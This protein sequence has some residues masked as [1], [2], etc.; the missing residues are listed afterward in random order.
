LRFND[1]IATVLAA[2][3]DGSV[4]RGILWRQ[5]VDL[6][7][8]FDR[9]GS[10]PDEDAQLNRIVHSLGMLR[11]EIT[12]SQRLASIIELGPR[13]QS[14]RLIHF[15]LDDE[16]PVV[17]AAMKRAHLEETQW[18]GLIAQAGPLARS[19]LRQREDLGAQ[20]R[21]ALDAFGPTDLSLADHS[22]RQ[23]SVDEMRAGP[24]VTARQHEDDGD[25]IRKIVDRIE[26]FTSER[27][28]RIDGARGPQPG[29]P[30]QEPACNVDQFS[31]A[32]D[33]Q[34]ILT[35]VAGAPSAAAVGLQ[36]G[37]PSLDRSY[38]ADGQILGAFKRRGAFRD[39]RF[40]IGEGLLQGSWLVCADPQFDQ[41]SGRFTGY[42]GSA[43]KSGS[44]E[45]APRLEEAASGPWDD[46]GADRNASASMRQLIHELRTPLN[47]V[48]GF[49][50]IIES[51]LLG[52]VNDSYRSMAGEIVTDVRRLVEILD[53]LDY[54]SRNDG[55]RPAKLPGE[56]DLAAL[57]N[58]A[59]AR[60]A[61][62]RQGRPRM[63][64][65][66]DTHP[67]ALDIAQAVA[68]RMIIHLVRA[69]T[70]CA[71]DETLLAE[72]RDHLGTVELTIAR[73]G[74]MIGLTDAQLFD[75]GFEHMATNPDAPVLGV[76]FGLRLVRRLA[77]ANKG[78]FT[79]FPDHFSLLLPSARHDMGE[80]HQLS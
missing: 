10:T 8:Q 39:G 26:R 80:R 70:A 28:A 11:P 19:V 2:R 27:Q 60:F 79:A 33:A 76:G 72:C 57:F 15:L 41:S 58:D 45:Q 38:G 36:I 52:P 18:P 75:S 22:P 46:Q 78:A 47:G 21:R 74:S 25:Q 63:R 64:L 65:S 32:T 35:S 56:T 50:E 43:R 34:G 62:D 31:F 73:P 67:P 77:Y 59:I 51:Q 53:D 42:V 24:A 29:R 17:V 37:V 12:M 55:H 9:G 48:M 14:P 4:T 61:L 23:A 69:L 49:A 54:A 68:E 20:A 6:L 16:A 3:A 30:E 66:C 71:G 7:A 13:L 1:L 40:A 44:L 5:C